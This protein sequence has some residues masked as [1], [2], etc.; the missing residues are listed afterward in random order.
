M[1]MEKKLK[2]D[3]R[4]KNGNN[5]KHIDNNIQRENYIKGGTKM[6]LKTPMKILAA[7]V[8]F[9]CFV[10]WKKNCENFYC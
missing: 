9:Y 1:G 10:Y 6:N 8:P 4:E 3:E 5:T 7:N 2:K